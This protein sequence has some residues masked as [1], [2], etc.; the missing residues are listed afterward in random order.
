ML[1][2]TLFCIQLLIALSIMEKNLFKTKINFLKDF[3]KKMDNDN[4]M[5]VVD[6]NEGDTE[7]MISLPIFFYLLELQT[8]E[9]LKGLFLDISSSGK[10]ISILR[11]PPR[12]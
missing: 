3:I 11:Y 1:M 4:I 6:K 5:M 9:D 2:N 10:R 12:Y 7:V 8:T